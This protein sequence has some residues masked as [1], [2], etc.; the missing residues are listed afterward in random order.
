MRR[1]GSILKDVRGIIV[2]SAAKAGGKKMLIETI[3]V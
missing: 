1:R 2:E 3:I